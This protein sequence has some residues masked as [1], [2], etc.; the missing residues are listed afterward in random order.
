MDEK[1]KI[2]DD[3]SDIETTDL[4]Q[5]LPN[6]FEFSGDILNSAYLTWRFDA[7][8]N[9][10]T[11]FYEL[12]KAY[13]TTALL[14]IDTCLANNRDKKAD[15]WIFPIMFHVVHGIEVYLKGFR[16]QYKILTKLKTKEYQVPNTKRRHEINDLCD[17][18]LDLLSKNDDKIIHAE[19]NFVRKFIEILFKNTS[20]MTFA[21]YPR[22]N[23][24]TDHFYVSQTK[25]ITIDLN[26][27]K[28]WVV[29]VFRILDSSTGF[30]DFQIDELKEKLYKE[31][32]DQEFIEGDM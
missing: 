16:S 31:Q 11:K 18:V 13:F 9:V 17:D 8:R 29:R 19:F 32:H 5:A 7:K 15:T 20:D 25:N 3:L 2:T 30:I 4:L 22:K 23:N 21:R 28:A 12:G 10:E 1:R 27:F 26:I 14:L 24:K 6:Y